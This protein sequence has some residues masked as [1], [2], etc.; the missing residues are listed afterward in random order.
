MVANK[1]KL[2]KWANFAWI[3]NIQFFVAQVIVGLSFKPTYSLVN[4]TI[5]DLGNTECSLYGSREV[6]SS[7]HLPMNLSFI[8]LG[9]TIS[10][11]AFI[12]WRCLANDKLSSLG[13][14]LLGLSGLGSILVGLYPE[15]S[16]SSAHIIGAALSFIFGNIG[17]I[18]VS[19]SAK[20]SLKRSLKYIS[21]VAGTIAL[22]ATLLLA[23]NNYLYL[24]L[25]GIERI[26]AYVQTIWMTAFGINRA[27][28][29]NS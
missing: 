28:H 29:S 15:N 21:V 23:T 27:I 14:L 24:G 8:L 2:L 18:L 4:N 20:S 6:C 5:S 17:L 7:L 1:K 16:I 12:Y 10:F 13:F 25:G 19:L 26:A 9:L 22:V 11:G 3:L